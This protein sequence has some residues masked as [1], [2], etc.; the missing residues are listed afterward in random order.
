MY[1]NPNQNA[2]GRYSSTASTA[3]T[4]SNLNDTYNI[5]NNINHPYGAS[6]AT[7][8]ANIAG[9]GKFPT[10]STT[11]AAIRRPPYVDPNTNVVYEVNDPDYE[12]WLFKQSQWLK[13]RNKF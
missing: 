3:T 8:G 6:V 13:V 7:T 9:H 10:L 1:N 12:G 5:N 11:T 2:V 4:N